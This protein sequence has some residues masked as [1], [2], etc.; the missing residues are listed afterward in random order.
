MEKK[1]MGPGRV[2]KTSTDKSLI[3]VREYHDELPA[4]PFELAL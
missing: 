2:V 1:A 3:E 4:W